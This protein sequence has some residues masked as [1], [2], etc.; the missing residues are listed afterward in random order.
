MRYQDLAQ[1]V[2]QVSIFVITITTV[3]ILPKLLGVNLPNEPMGPSDL[4][5]SS[6]IDGCE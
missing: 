6:N 4:K 2:L 3:C 5:R 1:K